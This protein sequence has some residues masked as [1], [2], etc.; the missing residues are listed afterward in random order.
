MGIAR[1]I[2]TPIIPVVLGIAIGAGGVRMWQWSDYTRALE[3]ERE[4]IGQRDE[5]VRKLAQAEAARDQA[6]AR[7]RKERQ[8]IYASDQD[9]AAWARQPV[10]R[11][12]A[13]RVQRAARN[14]D[15]TAG[16][17]SAGRVP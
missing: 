16:T 9:A 13:E 11:A 3:A 4:A 5:L 10:P 2:L 6:Q 1:D 17:A 15:A 8:A 12:I 14:A 7:A